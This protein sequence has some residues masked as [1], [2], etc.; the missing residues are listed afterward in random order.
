M[1]EQEINDFIDKLHFR[2]LNHVQKKVKEKFPNLKDD[3]LKEIVD[4]RLKDKFIKIC[5]ITPYY[6][7]I[8][9]TRP[10]CW[11]HD[12]MDNGRWNEPR[13]W[14][15]FLGT[16]NHYAV[17]LPLDNKQAASIRKTLTEFVNKFHP[18]KLTSDEEAGF[19]EK[20][21]LKFLTDNHVKIHII[22]EQNHSSLG[23]IDRFIRTLRDMNIPTEKKDKQSHDPKYQTFTPKRMEKLLEIYNSTYHSRINCSP[24]EMLN[25]P[26]LEKEYIFDQ[27]DKKDKQEKIKDFHLQKGA[28]VRYIIPRANGRRKRF[29]ISREC[30]K[31]E[32]IKGNMY[33]LIARDG[34]VKN[35]PRFKIMLCSKDGT[36]PS[37]IKWADTIPGA[38]NGVVKEIKSFDEKTRKYTVT[39]SVP[40][41]PDYE[42]EVP[43]TYL[44][45]NF[46]QQLSEMEKA[47]IQ[48]KK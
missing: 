40:G 1:T 31:I 47:Y 43:E 45:G 9:S 6:V 25:N 42:D 15:I 33:T 23:T 37:N 35:L 19:I 48:Q 36:K 13:Y 21:N 27:L 17:A 28:F 20:N 22:T 46:P 2:T 16:N 29:Q 38:W 24:K 12:L 5:K 11:F 32:E 41:Q 3:K 8:F 10:N 26:D 4:K 14:H 34:T 7:K 39:F 44:R 18:V 30:Y